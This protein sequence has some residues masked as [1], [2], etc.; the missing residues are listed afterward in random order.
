VACLLGQLPTVL[1]GHRGEQTAYVIAH[2]ATE[3]DSAEAMADG[4][5]EV[6]KFQVPLL[7]S[8]L[9]DHAGRLPR[10]CHYQRRCRTNEGRSLQDR[11]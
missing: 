1:P 6:V 10:R 8:M 7:G 5:E 3:L 4:H 2:A 11:P 9:G